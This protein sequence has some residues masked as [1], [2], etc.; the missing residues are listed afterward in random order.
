MTGYSRSGLRNNP[1]RKRFSGRTLLMRCGSGWL[2]A[3]FTLIELLVVISIIAIL[4]S[5]L[6]PAVQSA[7]EAARRL[8]CANHLKQLGLAL[9][10]Y[11]DSHMAFP[12]GHMETGSDGPSYRHQFGWLTY[13]LPYVEQSSVYDRI[14]FNAVDVNRSAH[15][16]PAFVPAGS[17][18]VGVFICPSDPVGRFNPTWAPTNYLG[19]QG[20]LC[21]MR[22]KDGNGLFGHDS[23]I[24][25]AEVLDG[26]SQTIAAAEVLKGDFQTGTLRDNYIFVRGSADAQDVDTCQ[27]FAP[28]ASDRGGVWLG[29][30]PQNN[31]FSTHRPPN[32][33]RFDCIAPNFGCTNIA[34]R[35]QHPGG[36]LV[37]LADGSVHFISQAIDVT[38]YRAMG[39]RHGSDVVG[40]Y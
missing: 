37:V 38:T 4:V 18:W 26:A 33:P 12:A 11:H 28:N 24:R 1:W 21:Y 31:M 30:N 29:G 16:N 14:D 9:H 36:A 34:A 23:W 19:N 40:E 27:S 10:N 8:S 35:S 3:G 7:R 13:L 20:T 15:Q 32:D 6:L 17:I 22:R 25:L 5:L 2:R 39:T